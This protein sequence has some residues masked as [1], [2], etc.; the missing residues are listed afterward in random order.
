MPG[1]F[2]VDEAEEHPKH[3]K[4]RTKKSSVEK[5]TSIFEPPP[6]SE[7]LTT[8]SRIKIPGS[9]F[10]EDS[11][12]EDDD[13][14]DGER[15]AHEEDDHVAALPPTPVPK[16]KTRGRS[17]AASVDSG[18]DGEVLSTVRLRRSSRLSSAEPPT[19]QKKR[20]SRKTLKDGSTTRTRKRKTG[21]A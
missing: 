6:R 5:T 15:E 4:V 20:T 21:D 7:H 10:D 1:A 8:R 12:E 17:S 14:N 16:R 3:S 19:P 13:D 2:G 18:D 9:L 11:H